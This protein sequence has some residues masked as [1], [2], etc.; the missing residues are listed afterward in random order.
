MSKQLER[1]GIQ[2][3]LES[4]SENCCTLQFVYRFY[5]HGAKRDQTPH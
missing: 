2:K 1:A 3:N 4:L 5:T